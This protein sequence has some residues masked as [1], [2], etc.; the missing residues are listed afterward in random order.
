MAARASHC[1]SHDGGIALSSVSPPSSRIGLSCYK[2]QKASCGRGLS[3]SSQRSSSMA[4]TL[5]RAAN[6]LRSGVDAH[7]G[8]AVVSALRQ[9]E[10]YLAVVS[11]LRRAAARTSAEPSSVR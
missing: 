8:Q 4:A 11:A 2:M 5:G 9:T 10:S 7:L 6:P 3:S 1:D